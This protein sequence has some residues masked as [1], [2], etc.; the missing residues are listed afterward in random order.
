MLRQ[1]A[2]AVAALLAGAPVHAQHKTTEIDKIFSFATPETPGCAVGASQHGKTVV[3]RAYGLANLERGTPLSASSIF[4]IGSAQKQF[5]AAS[6]LLLVEDGRLSLSDDIRKLVP[7]LPDYGHKITL[8]HLLTHT[9]GIR[10][11]TGLRPFSEGDPEVLTLILRQR[12]LNFAPGEEWSYSNSGYVLLKE[13]VARASGTSFADFARKRLF[14]PLGMMSSAYVADI[15]Q[16]SGNIALGYQKDGTSWKQF[17]RL[18]NNRG[19][20]AVISTAGDLLIWNDALTSGRLG[21]VVT[22]KLQETARLSNGRKLS[23]ARGLMVNTPGGDTIVS[24]SGGAAGY[25]TW[26]GRFPAHGLSI[27]VLCNFDPVSATAL[28]GRVSDLFLPPP[29]PETAETGA[30]AAG[31]TGPDL[32]SKAGLFFNERTGEPL[33]LVVNEGTL[34]I[35]GGGPLVPIA[36]D[37][38]RNTR[39][40]L[41][42]MSQD[43]FELHFPTQDGLELKSMEGITTRYRRAQPYSPTAADL[44]ALAGRYASDEMGAVFQVEPAEDR[45]VILLEHSPERTL[46]FEPV[47]RDVFQLARMIVRF[48]RDAAGKVVSLDYSNPVVRDIEFV[49][50]GD[51]TAGSEPATAERSDSDPSK[52][53]PARA[54]L[55]ALTGF[56]EAREGR[57]ITVT[58]ENGKLYGEPTG[59]AKRELV[60]Q[61]GTTYTVAGQSSSV[62]LKFVLG[63]DGRPTEMVMRQGD[64]ER[65]FPKA[66]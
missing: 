1:A 16:G 54:D 55:E 24:H 38:F 3:N 19:G 25:S 34:Q 59:N 48:Q 64:G 20:G 30:P 10:D 18:G 28:A 56:Y 40:N 39:G 37:R 44:R 36:S 52:A 62:T 50:V 31:S 65:R 61:S 35:F 43:E 29:V 66:R 22:A 13:I 63:D 58:V 47:E 49:R 11:W 17:M 23:Y 27:A 45:L 15:L 21:T 42:F 4:D 51:L 32:T 41:F 33:R 8:D 57:G 6:V 14:E 53:S 46:N 2:F 9:S 60:L 12:G 5:V 7:E 26:L